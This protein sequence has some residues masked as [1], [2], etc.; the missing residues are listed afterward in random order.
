MENTPDDKNS[1]SHTCHIFWHKSTIN[2]R[3]FFGTLLV[4]AKNRD[5]LN[6]LTNIETIFSVKKG[7]PSTSPACF[8]P[9]PVYV[10][11]DAGFGQKWAGHCEIGRQKKHVFCNSVHLGAAV[12]STQFCTG[13]FSTIVSMCFLAMFTTQNLRGAKIRIFYAQ[14]IVE[15]FSCSKWWTRRTTP[16]VKRRR[17]DLSKQS[18][19]IGGRLIEDCQRNK[20][21]N[22]SRCLHC[23]LHRF[24]NWL[25]KTVHLGQVSSSWFC[26]S[27]ANVNS[28]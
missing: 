15:F 5:E 25:P 10:C 14:R 24:N 16:T 3:E 20:N 23:F 1:F 2:L 21:R 17:R 9:F 19:H 11:L 28:T 7:Q 4:P 18:T 12:E 13:V 26:A 22:N 6:F 8:L 27:E